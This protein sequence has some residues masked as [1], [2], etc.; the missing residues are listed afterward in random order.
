MD[1]TKNNGQYNFS[2]PVAEQVDELKKTQLQLETSNSHLFIFLDEMEARFDNEKKFDSV[3]ICIAYI[4]AAKYC[5]KYFGRK[6]ARVEQ[7]TEWLN[8]QMA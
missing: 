2:A 5:A 3:D 4:D 7:A 6:A 8:E 1:A